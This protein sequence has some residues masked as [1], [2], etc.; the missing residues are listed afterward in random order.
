M[1]L[2][3]SRERAA[4]EAAGMIVGMDGMRFEI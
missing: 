3:S 2:E 4:V 1:L